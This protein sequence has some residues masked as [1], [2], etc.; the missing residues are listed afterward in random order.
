MILKTKILYAFFVTRNVMQRLGEKGK[1][2]AIH[3]LNSKQL[4]QRIGLSAPMIWRMERK[5]EF[6]SRRKIS[7]NRV[8]WIEEEVEAWLSNRV[9]S[10][11]APRKKGEK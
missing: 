7:S 9:N 8:G 1:I 4:R 5:G 11:V 10:M 3:I 2:M 6:P